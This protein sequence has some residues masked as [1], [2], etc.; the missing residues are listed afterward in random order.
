MRHY[1]STGHV[2]LCEQYST[3]GISNWFIELCK[4]TR[5]TLSFR[6]PLG[7]FA[8][9]CSR[10]QRR[11]HSHARHRIR[12][13]VLLLKCHL[14]RPH[15]TNFGKS[16]KACVEICRRLSSPSHGED[17]MYNFRQSSQWQTQCPW[18]VR[19]HI[20]RKENTEMK[21][22]ICWCEHIRKLAEKSFYLTLLIRT[23]YIRF[24]V[25]FV[26]FLE[27][28]TKNHRPVHVTHLSSELAAKR[29]ENYHCAEPY[30]IVHKAA[31]TSK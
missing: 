29:L 5:R 10:Q 8:K 6:T 14:R 21:C 15:K 13:Y 1:N 20:K 27:S 30:A 31:R 26:L 11:Q 7:P 2:S 23:Q 4:Q 9:S 3:N 22:D 24:I 17:E 18:M 25:L 19:M 12:F 16:V 28:V